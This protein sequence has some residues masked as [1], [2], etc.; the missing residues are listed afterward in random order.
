M[1]TSFGQLLSPSWW[2][3]PGVRR[4]AYTV[5]ESVIL[6]TAIRILREQGVAI[7]VL[8]V[9]NDTLGYHALVRELSQSFLGQSQ[10]YVLFYPAHAPAAIL[11][12]LNAFFTTYA[13][14]HGLTL[15]NEAEQPQQSSIA[16]VAKLFSWERA[17]AA[18]DGEQLRPLASAFLLAQHY[19]VIPRRLHG[20]AGSLH[21]LF[22]AESTAVGGLVELWLAPQKAPFIAAWRK[23]YDQYGEMFWVAF[24]HETLWRLAAV[25]RACQQGDMVGARAVGGYKVPRGVANRLWKELSL[26]RI[27]RLHREVYAAD[28]LFKRN[29]T[30]T[31]LDLFMT[32]LGDVR[33]AKQKAS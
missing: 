21:A 3:E 24:W 23:L 22:Q 26:E 31:L 20:Q 32:S 4:C 12:K 25:V 7:T 2:S 33:G 28:A 29:G 16:A 11:K 5:E 13:G 14:P 17:L 30:R 8:P 18:P 15:V 1:R 9:P 19:A 6:I 27:A 10:A